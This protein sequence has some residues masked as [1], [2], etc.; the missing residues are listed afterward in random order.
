MSLPG[1]S[2]SRVLG[3]L[4]DVL[5]PRRCPGCGGSTWPFC[6]R[7]REELV[8]LTPPWC[9]RC[10]RPSES[11]VDV[12]EEC[13]PEPL[14]SARAPFL[15]SGAARA[16]IHRL[17]FAGWRSAAEALGEAMVAVNEFG[18]DAVTWVPLSR[19]RL[20]ER[21]YDQARALA[22]IVAERLR[23]PCTRL[24]VR[25][26][27]TAPQARRT[28]P[29]RRRAMLGMFRLAG[30]APPSR[31]LLVDD[32]L[33]TGATAA[34]CARAL[35]GAGAV[36]VGLLAAARAVSGPLPGEGYTRLGSRLGL[37]LPG[38]PPR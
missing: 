3:S 27:S 37:W 8:P 26:T 15:F 23:L 11:D 29:E 16:A 10:G 1:A 31:V 22:A 34:G 25:T 14:V 35:V 7:C 30:R 9:T 5:F 4:F 13:P 32:V 19:A 2:V 20:A 12:C 33:T 17:K 36:E 38:D 24:V 18:A 28:G 6:E 21:G